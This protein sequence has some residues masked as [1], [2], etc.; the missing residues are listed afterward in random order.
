MSEPFA[1]NV[2]GGT[3]TGAR[4]GS[5]FPVVLLHGWP[6]TAHAWRFVV[7]DLERDHRVIAFNLPGIGGSSTPPRDDFST[8]AIAKMIV[9]GLDVL[10]IGQFALMGHDVGGMVGAAVAL[11]SRDRVTSLAIV[12][13]PLPGI[14]DWEA[15]T[16]AFWHFG[17]HAT[18][19]LPEQLVR[20]RERDYVQFFYE[21]D[22][23]VQ[24]AVGR[25]DLDIYAAA[26][27]EG[28]ALHDGFEYYRAFARSA[29]QNRAALVANGKLE[30]PVLAVAGAH[31]NGDKQ[32]ARTRDLAAN[33]QG[34]VI[35]G[36]GHFVA[37]E[38]PRELLAALR[39]FLTAPIARASQQGSEA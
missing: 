26:Y 28:T 11:G 8:R 9:D 36:C 24:D 6:M 16:Q 1:I 23:V 18:P 10:G 2:P 19:S 37:E 20:G 14:S 30:M 4:A 17:F 27:A 35:A 32:L 39:S 25:H 3:L 34:A 29:E 38:R 21:R 33:V 31:S 22:A 15:I 13:A 12:E 5:G 7:P